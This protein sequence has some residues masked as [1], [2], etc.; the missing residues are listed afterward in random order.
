MKITKRQLRRIIRESSWG[1]S[2]HDA[3]ASGM[4]A[5]YRQGY[6]DAFRSPGRR[7]VGANREYKRGYE[8]GLEDAKRGV[9]PPDDDNPGRGRMRE[10]DG[11]T[12]KYDD[13]SALRG[14]Q[15][16]L[17][18]GL[19]RAI[20]D[21]TVE[22]REDREEK[23]K[24]E[25]IKIT[26]SRL[27]RIIREVLEEETDIFVVIGNLGRG[28]QTMWPKSASPGVYSETEASRIADEQNLD[29]RMPGGARISWHHQPLSHDLLGGRYGVQPGNEAYIGLQKLLDD[30]ESGGVW[31]D[32]QDF[33]AGFHR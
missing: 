18:D 10:A 1:R 13:D 16:D 30:Y 32:E 29:S 19:Q 33:E 3:E 17:P 7:K 31:T 2:E 21:K 25:S 22:D 24:N 27:R 4:V 26:K 9:R 28:Q 15:S 8:K 5:S 6:R 14:K 20:I 23:E 12:K 11:S